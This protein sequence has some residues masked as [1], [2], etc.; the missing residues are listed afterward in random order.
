M[1]KEVEPRFWEKMQL[2]SD[3]KAKRDGVELQAGKPVIGVRGTEG[4]TENSLLIAGKPGLV[5]GCRLKVFHRRVDGYYSVSKAA[6]KKNG[7]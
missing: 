2:Q 4:P 1:L 7:N 3:N 6:E 5:L